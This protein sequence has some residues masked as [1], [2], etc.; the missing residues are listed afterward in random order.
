M[1]LWTLYT[2]KDEIAVSLGC[3]PT[4]ATY[5]LA[6][7]DS[8]ANGVP[9][10][11]PINAKAKATVVATPDAAAVDA[12]EGNNAA[13]AG[14]GR[15]DEETETKKP[16]PKKARPPKPQATGIIVVITYCNVFLWIRGICTTN[17][18]PSMSTAQGTDLELF[19]VDPENVKTFALNW[20]SAA[21]SAEGTRVKV[22]GEL[23]SPT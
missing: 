12:G 16:P 9:K 19:I 4:F 20:I 1:L 22:C 13:E 21:T 18:T 7:L 14:P 5:L 8:N 11:L 3:C 6:K 10:N 2:D 17:A 23:L 15:D